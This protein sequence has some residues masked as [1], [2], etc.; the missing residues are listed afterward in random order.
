MTNT[1]ATKVKIAI[2][3]RSIDAAGNLLGITETLK[4]YE[5]GNIIVSE[6]ES[7]IVSLPASTKVSMNFFCFGK[8]FIALAEE[9]FELFLNNEINVPKSEFYIPKI[10]DQFIK[11]GRGNIEVIPTDAKW[12]GVTYKEDAPTVKKDIHDLVAT[13]EYPGSLWDDNHK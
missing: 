6:E 7:G 10:A 11:L 9:L 13:G 4:I 1:L 2:P 12:F 5:K 3:L 8:S